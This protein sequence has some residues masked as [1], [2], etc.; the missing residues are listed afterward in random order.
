MTWWCYLT[1]GKIEHVKITTCKNCDFQ[2]TRILTG[3][4][5]V[6]PPIIGMES[7]PL[8]DYCDELV[9]RPAEKSYIIGDPTVH[10]RNL[11]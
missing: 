1:G 8:E 7:D 4:F 2:E 11:E 5:T 6:N 9:P 10:V 3:D